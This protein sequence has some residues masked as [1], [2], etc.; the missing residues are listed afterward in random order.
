MS[1]LSAIDIC[2]I[3]KWSSAG[4]T[5][6]A[7]LAKDMSTVIVMRGCRYKCS[8]RRACPE[9]CL[10]ELQWAKASMLVSKPREMSTAFGRGPHPSLKS[11]L[12]MSRHK[13]HLAPIKA[14]GGLPR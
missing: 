2:R 14:L 10:L 9:C 11:T 12:V 4:F 5:Y 6:V 13:S 1:A 8:C 7:F 3:Q